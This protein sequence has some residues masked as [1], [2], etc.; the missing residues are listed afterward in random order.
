MMLA[1]L[2]FGYEALPPLK[3]KILGK[4]RLDDIASRLT[5]VVKKRIK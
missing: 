2:K 5:E 4:E 3:E 1:G